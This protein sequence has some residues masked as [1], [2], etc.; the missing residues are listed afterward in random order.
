MTDAK[1]EMLRTN[2]RQAAYYER[3]DGVGRFDLNGVATNAWRRI[4]HRAL[5]A[6][7]P[8][9]R[10]GLDER[11][12]AWLADL[13]GKKVLELGSGSGSALTWH[14]AHGAREYHAIDL[15]S[16]RIA[17]LGSK[18]AGRPNVTL[19]VGDVLAEDYAEAGFDVIYARSMVHHF[20]H[21]GL[22]LDKLDSMLASGGR[23]V[24][25]DPV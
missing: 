10:A 4:R 2:R 1:E 3:T 11:H 24:T 7:S 22:L 19:H 8:D 25:F 18:L 12:R 5:D 20:R 17:K 23:I 6:V 14:L 13:S 21:L 9:G 15:S 16:S